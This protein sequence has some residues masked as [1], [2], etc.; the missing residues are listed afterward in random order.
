[1]FKV[2]TGF[3]KAV[4]TV[5]PMPWLIWVSMLGL[6]NGVVPL[7]F[8]EHREAQV[9]FGATMLAALIQ[10]V[11]F[12]AKGY[13]RLLGIGHLPWLPVVLW[14]ASRTSAIGTDTLF[15]QWILAVIVIDG[16]CLV[17]D[18]VDVGRYIAG[19]RTPATTLEDA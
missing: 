11:I 14:L 6:L 13:V 9:L 7:F 2:M 19:E 8:L 3:F 15:G 5:L 16:L 17:I 4:A 12:K 18:V 1:M 10:M